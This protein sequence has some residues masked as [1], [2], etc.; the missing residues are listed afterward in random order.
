MK[1]GGTEDEG[2]AAVLS[3]RGGT[4]VQEDWGGVGGTEHRTAE[5]VAQA[6]GWLTRVVLEGRGN[7]VEQGDPLAFIWN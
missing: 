1:V 7:P 2:R 4:R 6:G 3:F 5:S